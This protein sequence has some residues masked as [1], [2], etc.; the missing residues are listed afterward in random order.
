[1][2]LLALAVVIAL[3]DSPRANWILLVAAIGAAVIGSYSSLQGL[4][5]WPAGL[6]VL[7]WRHRPRAQ[8]MTWLLTAVVTVVV[9]FHNFDLSATDSGQKSYL[10][11]H[12]F[13]SLEFFFLSI[14]DVMGKPLPTGPGASDPV[15][16]AV[17]VTVF[18]LAVVSLAVYTRPGRLAKSP[19]GPAL[20]CFGLL[21]ALSIT[22][23]RGSYGLAEASQSRYVLFDL[24]ILLG[25]YLCLIEGWP[26]P[27]D[28]G[29]M[30]ADS[31]CE[32]PTVVDELDRTAHAQQRQRVLLALRLLAIM[33][34]VWMVWAG[35]EN[36]IAT[37]SGA[38]AL[39]QRAALVS[40]HAEDAPNTLI[41]SALLP[42]RYISFDNVRT[43]AEL[44][45][46]HHLSFFATSEGS[47]LE[48]MELPKS[49]PTPPP[50]T[51]VVNPAGGSIIR[52]GEIFVAQASGDYLI[53]TVEF[54]ISGTGT[55]PAIVLH[56]IPSNFGYLGYWSSKV[57]PNGNYVVQSIARDVAGHVGTSRP[58]PFTVEN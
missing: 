6:I 40:A 56:G 43:L 49:G 50:L 25:C 28:D 14:G 22:F 13:S 32:A 1:M 7:L 17:G 35:A 48:H 41:E 34:I 46:E 31:E 47:R 8:V 42:N 58:V 44:A 18:L 15:I 10:L 27:S 39:M 12:P 16:V 36:G 33:L 52:K 30:V 37:G 2:I 55:A 4:F 54:R 11:A 19:V 45:K 57:V 29:T 9:Y 38:R 3:L 21:F 20:I 24:L 5:I 26:S 51:S 23:G 53:K